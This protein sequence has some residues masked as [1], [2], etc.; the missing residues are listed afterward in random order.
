[1][2]GSEGAGTQQCV[3]ATRLIIGKNQNS[4]IGTLVERT[5]RYVM[6]VH[7]PND[8]GAVSMRDA[9]LDTIATLPAHLRRSLTWDQG[10]EMG[11]PP[12]V[13]LCC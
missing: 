13:L 8:H 11:A 9:L 1:L 5:T 2:H 12:R 4:A 10:S 6:L 3:P 7:L